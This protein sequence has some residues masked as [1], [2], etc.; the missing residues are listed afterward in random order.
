V[1]L[2]NT[3]FS[4][5]AGSVLLDAHNGCFIHSICILIGYGGGLPTAEHLLCFTA[6][7]LASLKCP[8]AALQQRE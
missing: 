3:S 4:V 8:A 7:R 6:L 2:L 1:S 5:D